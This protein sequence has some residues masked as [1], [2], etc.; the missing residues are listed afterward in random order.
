MVHAAPSPLP[1]EGE[2]WVARSPWLCWAQPDA[3]P[4]GRN[5][6]QKAEPLCHRT[7]SWPERPAGKFPADRFPQL[8][9]IPVITV[10]LAGKAFLS[11][12]NLK[13]LLLLGWPSEPQLRPTIS[14]WHN[15]PGLP[16]AGSSLHAL[17]R[18][19]PVAVQLPLGTSSPRSSILPGHAPSPQGCPPSPGRLKSR[20]LQPRALPAPCTP[21]SALY[22]SG[23]SSSD[24]SRAFL[25]IVIS[26]QCGRDTGS[27]LL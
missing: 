20:F 8:F 15:R 10:S 27:W 3:H 14:S 11:A 12:K 22:P 13:T 9:T 19:F 2:R 1:E 23:L 7:P 17:G 5:Q 24:P 4:Q 6:D 18:P 25:L 16:G 26:P 21:F